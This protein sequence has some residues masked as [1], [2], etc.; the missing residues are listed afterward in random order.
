MS[1]RASQLRQENAQLRDRIALLKTQS[2][3]SD[4]QTE[5]NRFVEESK[6]NL[7]DM[8]RKIVEENSRQNALLHT[9]TANYEATL[10]RQIEL[11]SENKKL[12]QQKEQQD[13]IFN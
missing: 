9:V 6:R 7:N 3:N 13:A 4:L 11:L 12:S 10:K 1:T 5:I 8:N 2:V